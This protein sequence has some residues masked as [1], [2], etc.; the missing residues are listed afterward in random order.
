MKM[1]KKSSVF[2]IC[3]PE[4]NRLLRIG[5][6][7]NEVIE[8]LK[9]EKGLD[10][11]IM[12][13]GNYLYRYNKCENTSSKTD[14][15]NLKPLSKPDLDNDFDKNQKTNDLILDKELKSDIIN[16]NDNKDLSLTQKALN[17]SPTQEKAKIND[18]VKNLLRM[19]GN[20]S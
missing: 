6:S 1:Q 12:T 20:Q 4:I 8:F 11:S 2:R 16:D 17:F 15:E 13:F 14:N 10:L 3:L 9:N 19:H 5:H 18:K 7:H